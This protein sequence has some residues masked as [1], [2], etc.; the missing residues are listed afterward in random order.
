MAKTWLLMNSTKKHIRRIKY[1]H[2]IL[3]LC[4]RGERKSESAQKYVIMEISIGQ[5]SDLM[6]NVN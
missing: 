3:C 6:L 4:F 5:Y 2:E 1:K